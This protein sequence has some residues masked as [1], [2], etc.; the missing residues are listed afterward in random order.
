VGKSWRP[1]V[2][3]LQQDF[4]LHELGALQDPGRLAALA[5]RIRA[6]AA[7]TQPPRSRA[8]AVTGGSRLGASLLADAVARA[9]D[10]LGVWCGGVD[11]AAAHARAIPVT[12]TPD[13]LTDDVADL[14]LALQAGGRTP[15]PVLSVAAGA[16]GAGRL[17][18][19]HHPG[20]PA[21]RGLIDAQVLA[22]P[23]PNGY[24][25]NVGRGSV[26]DEPALVHAIA[27]GAIASGAIAGA[28]LDV[29]A[30]EPNVPAALCDHPNV[31]LTP[32]MAS[33]SWETRR[34][35]ADLALSNLQAHF[36]GKPL[37]TAVA[38][39]SITCLATPWITLV[40]PSSQD[41][42]VP[43]VDCRRSLFCARNSVS[44]AASCGIRFSR[45]VRLIHANRDRQRTFPPRGS[46]PAAGLSGAR[47]QTLKPRLARSTWRC[48]SCDRRRCERPT[49]RRQFLDPHCH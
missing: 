19:G 11:V 1:H 23:G 17:P 31:V 33:G 27:S 42:L 30:D 41:V 29:F 48:R 12:N 45:G 25:I 16:G 7:A 46:N 10:D 6:V 43:V 32:H 39:R 18:A 13:V 22:A 15:V 26:V 9:G 28:A 20:R 49:R 38:A 24:L 37:L 34:A 5:A 8:V 21:T 2:H 36:A 44:A 4:E 3:S 47:I 14:A 40:R 35:M